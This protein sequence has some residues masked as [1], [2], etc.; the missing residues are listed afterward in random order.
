MGLQE[1]EV[2]DLLL[3][4]KHSE[5]IPFENSE[6]EFIRNMARD[7]LNLK[8]RQT[9]IEALLGA[10]VARIAPNLTT[11]VGPLLSAEL[12][13]AAGGLMCLAKLHPH[14]LQTLGYKRF[15]NIGVIARHS[16]LRFC[17]PKLRTQVAQILANSLV[18]AVRVDAFRNARKDEKLLSRLKKTIED[19]SSTMKPPKK[20]TSVPSHQ[21]M[22]SHQNGKVPKDQNSQ[23]KQNGKNYP[24]S[25][26]SSP[27]SPSNPNNKSIIVKP[28]DTVVMDA[29]I[30]LSSLAI[31]VYSWYSLIKRE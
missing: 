22:S 30:L 2:E 26:P 20:V 31:G 17:P 13:A 16:A 29:T 12:L 7:V 27:S 9:E 10:D 4:A 28:K 21:H 25:N 14:Q 6:M 18:S 19:A 5:G 8:T 23:Q 11:L 15:P 3:R 1:D 24:I